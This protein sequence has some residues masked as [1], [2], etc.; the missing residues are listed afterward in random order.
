VPQC[1]AL[2]RHLPHPATVIRAQAGLRR[3]D[4]EANIRAANGPKGELRTLRVIHFDR[5]FPLF[6]QEQHES[7]DQS[8]SEEQAMTPS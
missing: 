2:R 7:P 8:R 4:A 3:L 6:K 5:A 1:E